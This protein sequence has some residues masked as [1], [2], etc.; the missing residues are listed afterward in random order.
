MNYQINEITMKRINIFISLLALGFLTAFTSC[1]SLDQTPEDYFTNNAFWKDA[2]QVDGYMTGLHSWLR[3][4]YSTLF[5]M[6]ELRGG[7]LGDGDDGTGTSVFNE[8]MTAQ[9]IIK[10]DLRA[11]NAYFSTWN[12]L[13]ANI[14]RVNLAINKIPELTFLSDA[15]KNFYLGQAYGIRAFYYY[16]LYATWGGVPLV[17]DAQILNGEISAATLSRPRAK[18]SEIMALI[19]KD[20]DASEKAFVA[21]GGETYGDQYNWSLYATLLLKA[22]VYTFAANVT[23]GDQQATGT[24][25]LQTAKTALQTIINSGKFEL[26][27]DFYQAFR[28][29]YKNKNKELIFSV[30]F[31]KTDVVYMPVI[32]QCLAQ[33]NYFTAAYDLNDQKLSLKNNDK[34]GT[35]TFVDGIVRYQYKETF[36]RSFDVTDT[37]RDFTF[38]AVKNSKTSA[39]TGS[40]FGVLMKKFAGTYYPDEGRHRLDS[41]GPVF[42]YAEVLLL[43]AEVEND[44]GNDPSTYINQ[45]RKRAYG[46]GYPVYTNQ[47][48]Y[49]N[50]LA[51]LSELD[52]EFVFEGKRWFALLRMKNA[53]GK[54]LVFEPAVNYP[55]IPGTNRTPILPESESYKMLWPVSVGTMTNDPAITQTP[56]YK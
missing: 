2:T 32:S 7:L 13:Y 10:Q 5:S 45:I 8:S 29:D 47:S 17:T 43:M 15:Y 51:I 42:R 30:P 37:R 34:Y 18:A 19:K 52:K 56:G 3:S 23:V 20:L 55:F 53:A 44:L 54:S 25:D 14:V 49:Q 31:N 22:E 36:W 27:D 38:F 26:K 24:A 12:G 4:S 11:D 50:T 28:S 21:Y 6:G 41:D 40:N 16:L 39:A 35:N 1:E 33:G 46:T 48:Q 9:T